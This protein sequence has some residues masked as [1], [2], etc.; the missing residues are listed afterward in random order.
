MKKTYIKPILDTYKVAT[1]NILQASAKADPN[2]TTD[3]MDAKGF[4]FF[5]FGDEEE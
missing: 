3:G 4:N 2:D 1:N 5:Y